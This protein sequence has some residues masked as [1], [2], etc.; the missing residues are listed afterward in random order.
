MSVENESEYPKPSLPSPRIALPSF[1]EFVT[2]DQNVAPK[3]RV[4][5]MIGVCMGGVICG[6]TMDTLKEDIY[7][8]KKDLRPTKRTLCIEVNRRTLS[9]KKLANCTI[10]NLINMLKESV[11]V[12]STEDIA[13]IN[14]WHSTLIEKLS[15]DFLQKT[16]SR[17][18][19]ISF[20]DRLRYV[21]CMIEDDIKVLYLNSQSTMNRAELD[22]RKSTSKVLTFHEQIVVL[23][24]DVLFEPESECLENLHM[25]FS[26]S[27]VL[28]TI[29]YRLTIE[30]SKE[31]L[32]TRSTKIKQV[33]DEL[34]NL[35]SIKR[36]KR[37]ESLG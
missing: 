24:N 32:T 14:K 37:R 5:Y 28:E 4:I 35:N 17:I 33:H 11:A 23:F 16:E 12:L 7:G 25:D 31:L 10:G 34:S 9:K 15:E 36:R 3:E 27:I 18:K 8:N 13:Y 6:F 2:N 30:K 20:N 26:E 21:H 29:D 19:Y 22:A 1:E